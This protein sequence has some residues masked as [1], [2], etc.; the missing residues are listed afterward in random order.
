MLSNIETHKDSDGRD[1]A[2]DFQQIPYDSIPDYDDCTRH[3]ITLETIKDK[4]MKHRY[5]SLAQC[6]ADFYTMLNN[7][8]SVTIPTSQV[9]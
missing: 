9:A 2:E 5:R 8:R 3:V 4:L 1:V 7:A 6:S